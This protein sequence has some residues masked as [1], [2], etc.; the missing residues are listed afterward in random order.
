MELTLD[1]SSLEG[2]TRITLKQE[3]ITLGRGEAAQVRINA[4][5]LSRLHASIMFRGGQWTIVDDG[6]VNGTFVNG[7]EVAQAGM[8]L[9]DGDVVRL[10]ESAII[11][12]TLVH[13]RVERPIE[14]KRMTNKQD[15]R[16]P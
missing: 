7:R 4:P 14:R 5:S 2:E 1:I 9:K 6:S 12:V 10:G 16:L 11:K 13:P 8:P 3:S 15:E